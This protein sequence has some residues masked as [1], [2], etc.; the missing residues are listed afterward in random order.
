[1]K[2]IKKKN[3]KSYLYSLEDTKKKSLEDLIKLKETY[4]EKEVDLVKLEKILNLYQQLFDTEKE[5]KIIDE[6]LSL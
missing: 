3:I 2:K 1:M 5:I 6:L 4:N